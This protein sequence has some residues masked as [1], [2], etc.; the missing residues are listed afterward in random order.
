VFISFFF[1]QKKSKKAVRIPAS[2]GRQAGC[3]LPFGLAASNEEE[4]I[5]EAGDDDD[6]DG[7]ADQ[8]AILEESE[9]TAEATQDNDGHAAHNTMAVKS[10][11]KRAIDYMRTKHKVTFTAAEEKLAGGLFPKVAGL[12]HRV[13]DSSTLKEEFDGQVRTMRNMGHIPEGNKTRLDRC[14]PTRWNSDLACLEAH[15]YFEPAVRAL[16]GSNR[17]LSAFELTSDQWKLAHIL[18]QCLAIFEG[19]TKLFS[20][21]EVPMIVDVISMLSNLGKELQGIRDDQLKDEDDPTQFVVPNI[22]RVA[23][24]AGMMMVDKYSMFSTQC[25]IYQIAIVMCPDRKLEWFKSN[26]FSMDEIAKIRKLVEDRFSS[27]YQKE[28]PVLPNRPPTA[29]PSR[30]VSFRF[31]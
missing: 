28:P 1:K 13:H 29:Q 7:G 5:L 17:N 26:G 23:A 9:L 2:S 22:V 6:A 4:T 10:I 20:Q 11:R 8:P 15:L 14:V 3:A 18:E 25:D 27:R 19:P 16:I 30:S 12:A 21:S 31:N 24:H